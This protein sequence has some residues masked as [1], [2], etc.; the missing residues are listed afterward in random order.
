[1]VSSSIILAIFIKHSFQQQY[2]LPFLQRLHYFIVGIFLHSFRG[3]NPMQT[4]RK[5]KLWY[6]CFRDTALD[7]L[8][9]DSAKLVAALQTLLSFTINNVYFPKQLESTVWF[10]K[11]VFILPCFVQKECLCKMVDRKL[12]YFAKIKVKILNI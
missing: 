2:F 11:M 1:M 12:V 8:K 7:R 4:H 6:N 10:I 3:T 5:L 9:Q